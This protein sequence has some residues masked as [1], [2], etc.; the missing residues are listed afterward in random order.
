MPHKGTQKITPERFDEVKKIIATKGTVEAAKATGY[1]INTINLV[2]ASKEHAEFRDR[3]K[4]KK[5]ATKKPVTPKTTPVAV[6]PVAAKRPVKAVVPPQSVSSRPIPRP[7]QTP[8]PTDFVMRAEVD[9]ALK[10]FEADFRGELRDERRA[11]EELRK[12]VADAKSATKSLRNEVK[13][14]IEADTAMTVAEV[15]LVKRKNF[16]QRLRDR[17]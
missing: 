5:Q 2:H 6:K 14:L 3:R 1:S 16:W 8:R 4:A 10:A 7:L 9:R 12:E 11:I 17:F 13:P 15:T